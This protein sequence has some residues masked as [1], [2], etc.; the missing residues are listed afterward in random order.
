KVFTDTN[1][2]GIPDL[3]SVFAEG[4]HY[5]MNLAFA[6]DGTL[7]LTH[8]NG[9]F[10]LRDRDGDGVCDGR[11]EIGRMET[12]GTYPHNGLHGIA[13]GPDGWLYLGTGENL[14]ED[15]TLHGSDG[16]QWKGS[17]NDG[18]FIFRCRPDGSHLEQFARGAWNLFSLEFDGD[19]HLFAVDN[20]PDGSPPCRLL[21]VVR[22]GDYGY[23]YRY[24]RSRNHPYVCWNGE[25]PGTLPMVTGT[26]EAPAGLLDARRMRLGAHYREGLL[27]ASWGDNELEWFRLKPRGVSF[28]ATKEIVA[29]GG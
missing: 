8:R 14:G 26:G 9:V 16:S 25:L 23:Q 5:A 2:D 20:D 24:G 10:I 12:K 11:T 21:H 22:G 29:R 1:G 17:G 18:A 6:P 7:Y 19:G 15:Y 13:F 27:V 4:F 28:T 3:P